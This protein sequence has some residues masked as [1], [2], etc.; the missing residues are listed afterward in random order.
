MQG[1]RPGAGHAGEAGGGGGS[2]RGDGAPPA[3]GRC[4]LP[5][6]TEFETGAPLGTDLRPR[7]QMRGLLA[8]RAGWVRAIHRTRGLEG[9]HGTQPPCGAW[10]GL[11]QD[12]DGGRPGAGSL[13]QA[14]APAG[15]L[16][17]T[18]QPPPFQLWCLGPFNVPQ[19]GTAPHGLCT[20]SPSA[21]PT[22]P[23]AGASRL[24]FRPAV[25]PLLYGGGGQPDPR[26][27]AAPSA[28]P[29]PAPGAQF[30]FTAFVSVGGA[31]C[32]SPS[33]RPVSS[34]KGRPLRA[35][36]ALLLAVPTPPT[37]SRRGTRA[38]GRD[39]RVPAPARKGPEGGR[40]AV[41]W[42]V[43]SSSAPSAV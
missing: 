18:S 15:G 42:K 30:F 7:R 27:A 12:A 14:R 21:C 2:Y 34:W 32:S 23:G 37:L 3:L 38:L 11:R 9:T 19:S 10:P 24:V 40:S 28:S 33:G 26:Q 35:G 1:G 36:A 6:R 22:P 4:G 43:T 39:R 25:L 13:L 8:V 41:P 5:R 16:V 31:T 17:S 20:C 29:H